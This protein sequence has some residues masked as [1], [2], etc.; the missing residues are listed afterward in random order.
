MEGWQT[1]ADDEERVVEVELDKEQG[2][3]QE[4]EGGTQED[5]QEETESQTQEELQDEPKEKASGEEESSGEDSED[6]VGRKEKGYSQSTLTSEEDSENGKATETTAK[7]LKPI[8]TLIDSNVPL[9]ASNT[10]FD[11]EDPLGIKAMKA[12]LAAT[13]RSK[14]PKGPRKH[15]AITPLKRLVPTI[16]LAKENTCLKLKGSIPSGFYKRSKAPIGKDEHKKRWRPGTQSLCEI[17]FYQ[18]SCNL[19]IHKLP[20]LRLVR[21]LLHNRKAEMCIQASAIYVLQEASEA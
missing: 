6:S 5:S 11:L 13:A 9:P 17:R 15:K 14:G 3:S 10:T 16:K 8:P 18:K 2:D 4:E 20:F 12:A 1:K 7:P 19:L 21:E